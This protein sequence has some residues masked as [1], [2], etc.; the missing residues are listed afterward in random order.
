MKWTPSPR[1]AKKRKVALRISKDG[2]I[3]PDGV[4]INI[5]WEQFAPGS[6]MFIPAVNLSKLDAQMR[7]Y[8]RSHGIVVKGVERIEGGLLGM[9]FWRMS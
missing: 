7:S 5:N 6:S 3:C 1:R 8:A 9:R 2:Q 4:Y